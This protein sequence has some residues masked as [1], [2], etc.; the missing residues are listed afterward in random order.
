MPENKTFLNVAR[1]LAASGH[2]EL[3]EEA[4]RKGDRLERDRAL[5]EAL[6]KH[7]QAMQTL[8]ALSQSGSGQPAAGS[9]PGAAN[10]GSAIAAPDG[11]LPS[12]AKAFLR[13]VAASGV[14]GETH[15][16]EVTVGGGLALE[17]MATVLDDP[18]ADPES[19]VR[20]RTVM[21]ATRRKGRGEQWAVRTLVVEVGE[22]AAPGERT[23]AEEGALEAPGAA[24][25]AINAVPR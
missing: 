15:I 18:W 5:E 21:L 9:A 7:Q 17:Y 6:A 8:Q 12:A 2:P 16:E 22:D 20:C 14:Q 13:R 10:I 3:A 19:D 4:M 25:F 1:Q 23:S 11:P 24:S